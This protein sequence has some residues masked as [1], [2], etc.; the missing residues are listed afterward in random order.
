MITI[1]EQEILEEVYKGSRRAKMDIHSLLPKVYDEELAL[2]LNRLAA[3]Y[4]RMEE[5]AENELLHSG[6]MP[7]SIGLFERTRRWAGIQASTALNI[8]TCHIADLVGQTERDNLEKIE[9]V[10]RESSPMKSRAW[11][12]ADEFRQFEKENLR[13]LSSYQS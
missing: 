3:G 5:Q 8:S 7:E 11:E 9:G 2:D 13:I 6:I 12:L 4:G 1:K 10:L